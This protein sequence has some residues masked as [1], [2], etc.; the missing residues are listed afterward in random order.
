M[1]NSYIPLNNKIIG[2]INF[3]IKIKT[4]LN[5]IVKPFS[6]ISKN[7]FNILSVEFLINYIPFLAYRI[8]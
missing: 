1:K 7:L 2:F 3:L 8:C 6:V 5:K 4:D